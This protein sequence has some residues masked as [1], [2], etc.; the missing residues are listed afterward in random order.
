MASPVTA[1]DGKLYSDWQQPVNRWAQAENS[2]HN[3]DV[4]KEIGM[5]GGTIP[6]TVHLNHFVPI[7]MD[8]WGKRWYERGTISMFYTFATTDREDVRA[9]IQE[10][11]GGDTEKVDAWVENPEGK[12]VAKGSLSIGDPS[13]PDYVRSLELENSPRDELRI[14]AGLHPGDECPSAEDASIDNGDGKGEYEGILIYPATMY[15]L[16][17]V[18]F[19]SE[20]IRRAVGFFGATEITMKN[21]PILLN[22]EYRRTGE[23]VCVGATP[24]T[25]FAWVDSRLEDKESGEVVAEMRHMTRWMKVSSKLWKE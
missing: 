15:G 22:R 2:I 16:L 1:E 6:G 17:N 24:K 8:R 19:P 12:I 20:K 10:P 7:I 14:L 5:R 11:S 3:D 23:V 9:V 13:E 21:G 18:G 4:A 25:E